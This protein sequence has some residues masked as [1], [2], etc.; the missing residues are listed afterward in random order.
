MIRYILKRVAFMAV[1]LAA[2]VTVVFFL[3]RLIPGGPFDGE[4]SLP[5]EVEQNLRAKYN[6]DAPLFE[7]YRDYLSDLLTGD[8]GPSFRNKDFSVNELISHGLPISLTIGLLA[9]C[10]A[11]VSG[12]LLGVLAAQHQGSTLDNSIRMFS[13]M[14]LALPPLVS[15]PLLV[16]IVAVFLNWLPAGGISTYKHYILPSIALS[17]PYIA[18]FARLTR[19]S[20]IDVERQPFV[21]TARAKGLSATQISIHHIF[22]SA[23]T[24]VMSFVGPSAAALLA[25][26]MIVEE[27]FSI[28][29]LGRFFVQGALTQDYTLVTGAVLVYAVLILLFNFL[30]DLLYPILDPRTRHHVS[31]AD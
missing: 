20:Y 6:L 10:F 23:A 26:S 11:L 21:L 4:R 8:L 16:L 25:G 15:G 3:L 2:V 7:Q 30:I 12:C 24:P 28:P 9:L 27:I 14:C 1:T 22:R 18:A 31:N 5:S 19:T 13:T 17:I 29:G